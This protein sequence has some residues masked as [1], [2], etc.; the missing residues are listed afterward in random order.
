MKVYIAYSLDFD[1]FSILGVYDNEASAKKHA[2][3]IG[4]CSD[5]ETWDVRGIC[6]IKDVTIHNCRFAAAPGKPF[7][8]RDHREGK[9][10]QQADERPADGI[11]SLTAERGHWRYMPYHGTP[12]EGY[13]NW[14]SEDEDGDEFFIRVQSIV[15]LDH[16]EQVARAK[17]AELTAGEE[18]NGNV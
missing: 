3:I 8:L 5:V 1:A 14:F 2:A 12:L 16:A 4:T 11:L 6:A 13:G 10:T 15:S 9:L 18:G 17:Y 7:L